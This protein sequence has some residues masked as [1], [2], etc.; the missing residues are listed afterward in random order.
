VAAGS[1]QEIKV[2]DIIVVAAE[3]GVSAAM[4]ADH[5]RRAGHRC[6]NSSGRDLRKDCC[7]RSQHNHISEDCYGIIHHA[8]YNPLFLLLT[9][10]CINGRNAECPMQTMQV[11]MQGTR[12]W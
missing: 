12:T 5:N 8:C 11:P 7:V 3:A 6:S 10:N 9:I 4:R 1:V 2:D